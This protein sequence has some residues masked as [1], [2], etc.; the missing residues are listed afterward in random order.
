MTTKPDTPTAPLFRETQAF[1]LWVP[2]VLAGVSGLMWYLAATLPKPVNIV[3]LF[4]AAAVTLFG[5]GLAVGMLRMTTE[6]TP[7]DVGVWFGFVPTYRRVVPIGKVREIEVVRYRPIADYGGWGIRYGRDREV[8]LNARSDR[9]VR[10][11]L[12]DGSRLLIGN[13]RADEL[14]EALRSSMPRE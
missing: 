7:V 3:F 10:L 8:A 11:H 4:I 5:I 12:A 2:L 1:G 14:A 13:Q 6:V 9:G